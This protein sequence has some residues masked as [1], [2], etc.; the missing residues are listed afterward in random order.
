MSTERETPPSTSPVGGVEEES[1][2][3]RGLRVVFILLILLSILSGYATRPTIHAPMRRVMRDAQ[4]VEVVRH[5]PTWGRL[6]LNWIKRPLLVR[7]RTS[8]AHE[9]RTVNMESAFTAG[10]LYLGSRSMIDPPRHEI[11]PEKELVEVLEQAHER[12]E[13]LEELPENFSLPAYW[14]RIDEVLDLRWMTAFRVYP[15]LFYPDTRT[16]EP[17]VPAMVLHIWCVQPA[18]EH[19]ADD[20]SDEACPQARR[21]VLDL[22]AD[23]MI[24]NDYLL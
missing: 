7:H 18:N 13:V 5:Q 11:R 9:A 22:E 19:D 1:R 17:P 16:D 12:Y 6:T 10:G 8:V 21:L 15:V 24:R 4:I 14:A 23:R 20:G 2:F 3:H